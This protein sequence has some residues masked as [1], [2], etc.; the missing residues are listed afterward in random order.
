MTELNGTTHR[1]KYVDAGTFK[2]GDT[3]KF[4]AYV[5]GGVA[6]QV[7]AVEKIA[8]K[9]LRDSLAAPDV[10]IVDFSRMEAPL[11]LLL[12]LKTAHAYRAQHGAL[13]GVWDTADAGKFLALAQ[14]VN[15]SFKARPPRLSASWPR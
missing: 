10:N 1:V 5:K 14:E 8:H 2:I 3:S 13:P 7:R 15:A 11:Q 6:K 9:S 4:G 12:A